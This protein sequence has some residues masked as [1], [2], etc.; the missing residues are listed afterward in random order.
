MTI[1]AQ[2]SL[3]S[4]TVSLT[5]NTLIPV[6]SFSYPEFTYS[7][8]QDEFFSQTPS[9][10]GD[11]V[12]YSIVSGS[13][14][15]GLSLNANTGVI[16]G[17]PS[18][19]VSDR[20]VTIKAE[21]LLDSK[22]VS[23]VFSVCAAITS[24]SYPSSSYVI[25]R[26]Q[27]FSV[28]PSVNTEVDL[29]S[30]ESGS[31]PS[32]LS[33]N[34][35]TGVISGVPSA[36][37]D[38]TVATIRASNAI[39]TRTTTITFSVYLRITAFGYPQQSYTL[40]RAESVTLSPSVTGD[41]VSY[42]VRSGSLI[43]GLSL[44]SNTGVISGTPS[45]YANSRQVT[46]EATNPLGSKSITLTLTALQPIGS[47]SYPQE[48]Y[49]F[50]RGSSVSVSASATGDSITYVLTNGQMPSGLYLDST[51]GAITGTPSV[52][53]T[54]AKSITITARNGLGSKTA[55]IRIQILQKPLT[56][57][58]PSKDNVFAVGDEVRLS[59][60]VVGDLLVFSITSGSLPSG[61][62]LIGSTGV[63]LGTTATSTEKKS[64]TITASNAVGALSA[65]ITIRVVASITDYHYSNT[66]Y[67]LVNGKKY[68][69]TPTF[70]GEEPAFSVTNGTLPD[71]LIL[72][73]VTGV[74]EGEPIDWF[75][76]TTVILTAKNSVSSFA[77]ELSFTVL[78]FSM[79]I[80][81][82]IPILLLLVIITLCVCCCCCCCSSRKKKTTMEVKSL[83][84][85]KDSLPEPVVAQPSQEVTNPSPAVTNPSPAVIINPVQTVPYS[86][87]LTTQQ[88][89]SPMISQQS[90]GGLN[91]TVAVMNPSM[92]VAN[93]T[94]T[95]VNPSMIV[96]NPTMTATTQTIYRQVPTR[97]ACQ[98]ANNPSVIV[99]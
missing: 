93:P 28:S 29:F 46:I 86:V 81:I 41:V 16:S 5:F 34:S 78:P 89:V 30:L 57:T 31:L 76:K 99:V 22:T 79:G 13:L 39:S 15:D 96:A 92:A 72:N 83:D 43:S 7:I 8:E 55:T 90:V 38:N 71:G 77:T 59:P 68:K 12:T 82:M 98:V 17:T 88:V 4:K 87:P 48:S 63:I 14:P 44:N 24:L 21:N 42:S 19:S 2:N 73:A 6:T 51:T 61:L 11:S 45:Q 1:K 69:L 84:E 49:V 53:I 80:L 32:G 18:Q 94:M 85:L 36:S 47:F 25:A 60:I 62:Q 64:I 75:L 33:L 58:Y 67:T 23:L 54:T 95:M 27:S 20:Q 10:T 70:T 97:N 56:V 91:R 52:S 40:S 35:A 66:E 74:I 65:T 37:V 26:L 3:G 9:V 50:A